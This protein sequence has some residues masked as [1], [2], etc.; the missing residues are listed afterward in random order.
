MKQIIYKIYALIFNLCS[1]L[2]PVKENRVVFVSMHNENFNDSLGSVFE[3]M[4][5]SGNY[6]FVFITRQDLEFKLKNVFRV[7]S[8]FFIKSRKLATG[9]YVFLNDNFLPMSNLN[10]SKETVITQ[11]WHG[12]GVFKKFGFAIAQND[13]VRRNEMK[14]NQKLSFVICTSKNVKPFYAEAFGVDENKVL[15][16]GSPR[17]DYFYHEE[18]AA[19]AKNRLETLYPNLK[20]KKLVLY[21][22]TFRDNSEFDGKILSHFDADRVAHDLGDDYALLVRL[23]PQVHADF[24]QSESAVDVTDFDDVRQLVLAC[25]VLITDYSSICMDFA[26]L[27]KKTV[28]FAYDIDEYESMRDF[29]FD[30]EAYVPGKVVKTAAE[31]AEAVKAPFD[32]EKNQKFKRFNFD[33]DDGNSAKRVVKAV[34]NQ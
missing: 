31:I 22:P 10:F 13:T 2:F 3:E 18:N 8:F 15:P 24:V 14:A 4:K 30:Y 27:E 26:L 28:F 21:A 17:T 9:K 33:F 6:E 12:E 1:R 11:L 20:G 32:K 5:K 23:H 25:D 34:T 7:F 29:Y 16:L 19:K